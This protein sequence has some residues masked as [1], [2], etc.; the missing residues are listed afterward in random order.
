MYLDE[1]FRTSNA[2]Y[3]YTEKTSQNEREEGVSGDGGVCGG[4][5]VWGEKQERDR[6]R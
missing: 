5:C 4:G 1:V 3:C 6:K 2:C